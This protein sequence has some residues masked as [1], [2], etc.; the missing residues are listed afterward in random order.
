MRLSIPVS[1]ALAVAIAAPVSLA[2]SPIQTSPSA[3]LPAGGLLRGA[4]AIADDGD[5]LWAIGQDW[6]AEMLADR[7]EFTPYLGELEPATRHLGYRLTAVGRDDAM[8]PAVAPTRRAVD[9]LEVTF[10]RGD[11]RE[12]YE[13]K[14][15]G[16][17][18]S[19]VFATKPAGSGDLVVHGQLSADMDLVSATTTELVFHGVC[20]GVSVGRVVGFD[21]RGQRCDGVLQLEGSTLELRLPAAFVDRA[22]APITV[23]PLIGSVFTV[24]SGSETNPDAAYDLSNDRWLVVCHRATSVVDLDVT[25]RFVESDG[26]LG[27]SVG[28]RTGNGGSAF[29]RVCNNNLRDRFVVAW[30]EDANYNGV[31]F[32]GDIYACTVSAL[33]G[34]V[35]T[36]KTISTD[37]E[38]EY[39]VDV[40]GN[41]SDV[42][43]SF[44]PK[45]MLAFSRSAAL[46][47]TVYQ[48]GR[49][50]HTVLTVNSDG[51]LSKS[52]TVTAS[53]DVDARRVG[54][55]TASHE[56][57]HWL[58]TWD[59]WAYDPVTNSALTFGPR[60]IWADARDVNLSSLSGAMEVQAGDFMP[61]TLLWYY[62]WLTGAVYWA[63]CYEPEVAGDGDRYMIAYSA[64]PYTGAIGTDDDVYVATIEHS[65][66]NSSW[67]VL[68]SLRAVHDALSVR[69][70]RAAVAMTGES[71]LVSY[72]GETTTEVHVAELDFSCERCGTVTD[73][74]AGSA[75]TYVF[76]ASKTDGGSTDTTN[77]QALVAFSRD[78]TT[79]YVDAVRYY[80]KAGVTEN[81]GGAC[82]T[83]T[84]TT[85]ATECAMVGFAGHSIRVNNARANETAVLVFGFE[86]ASL[87]CASGCTL[88]V[89]PFASLLFPF[90][91]SVTGTA[92]LDV[93][94][95]QIPEL[96]DLSY[97]VQWVV[98]NV[99]GSSNCAELGADFTDAKRVTIQ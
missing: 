39:D 83:G 69:T 2:Q 64:R 72:L 96:Q 82:G 67:Q 66:R 80:S 46:G 17:K 18:Q 15:E 11:V 76:L 88:H 77:E 99:N 84:T 50:M 62:P 28:I 3:N 45:V 26:T 75:P 29:A 91:T 98:S 71:F 56:H 53:L 30:E 95:P 4:A 93:A 97:Y 31:D 34:T 81:L 85:V 55:S 78:G 44:G 36:V 22:V 92:Q 49:V 24:E 58:L 52:S 10:E 5:H 90:T 79:K 1:C 42:D 86:E 27:S 33:D 94:I 12:V 8:R 70:R 87:S 47:T 40:G 41:T 13:A 25:G 9:G 23:D 73:V 37:V 32:N 51:S 48:A 35:G 16:L 20:G 74:A 59:M 21:A 63:E 65:K 43:D 61:Q 14:P 60:D 54:I 6:R 7:I 89:N 19:F 38:D 68:D 57:Q